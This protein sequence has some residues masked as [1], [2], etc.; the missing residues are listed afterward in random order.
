MIIVPDYR[1]Y[2]AATIG[3][4]LSILEQLR[5]RGFDMTAKWNGFDDGSINIHP[6]NREWVSIHVDE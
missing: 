1:T 4:V 6:L 3:D 2:S 5:D